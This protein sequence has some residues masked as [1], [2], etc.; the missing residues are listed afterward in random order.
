MLKKQQSPRTLKTN[1]INDQGKPLP[2]RGGGG[3]LPN[4]QNY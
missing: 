2:F 3:S 1:Y 4:G